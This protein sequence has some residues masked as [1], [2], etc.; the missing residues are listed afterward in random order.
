MDQVYRGAVA[1]F[2]GRIG[3]WFLVSCAANAGWIFAWHYEFVALSMA[4][5]LA[6]LGSL[7]AL[8]LRLGIGAGPPSPGMKY[9]VHI[10]VSV[11]LGWALV[12][13]GANLTALLVSLG[14]GFA[15]GRPWALALMSLAS[16][17]AL[18]F[19]FRRRDIFILCVVL[20]TLFG[21]AAR[22]DEIMQGAA[23]ALM[24]LIAF[25]GAFQAMRQRVY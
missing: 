16:L 24:G 14:A 20:W 8:Y 15:G 23:I 10:P 1:P 22:N 9:C 25:L 19:L 2:G 11:Y 7:A 5:L 12:A 4:V 18:L 3:P 17:A 21:I 6:L 13:S